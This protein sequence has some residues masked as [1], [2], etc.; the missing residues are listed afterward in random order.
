V[1]VRLIAAFA[2]AAT[3]SAA[4]AGLALWMQVADVG[5]DPSITGVTSEAR[6]PAEEPVEKRGVEAVPPPEN[7]IDSVTDEHGSVL[8]VR[9]IEGIEAVALQNLETVLRVQDRTEQQFRGAVR[10][11]ASLLSTEGEPGDLEEIPDGR[12]EMTELLEGS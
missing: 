2:L 5:D 12:E 9:G 3:A 7:A 11:A 8:A 1:N 4:A 10:A 6:G